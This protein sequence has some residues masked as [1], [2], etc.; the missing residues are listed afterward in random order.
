M[1]NIIELNLLLNYGKNFIKIVQHITNNIVFKEIL[2]N[3]I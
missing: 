1:I 2:V 3:N